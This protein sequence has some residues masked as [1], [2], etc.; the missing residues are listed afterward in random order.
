MITPPKNRFLF[1]HFAVTSI[2]IFGSSV[3]HVVWAQGLP[4]LP[5][6]ALSGPDLET[7]NPEPVNSELP[8]P[9][10]PAGPDSDIFGLESDNDF[11]FEKTPQQ[12]Q[13]EVRTQAFEA[14]LQGLM[15]LKPE[16]IRILLE[17][18]DRTQESVETPIYPPPKPLSVVE[19]LAM[20]PG[21]EPTVIKTAVGN[22]T[23]VNF[24][25]ITGRPWP[26][27]SV[28]WAG[29]FDVMQNPSNG[30]D[31]GVNIIRITP[32]TEYARGNMSIKMIGL[33]T[34][35]IVI[36]KSD[37][38]EVHYRFDATIPQNGPQADIPII[39]KGITLTAG[40]S[41]ISGLLQGI[42]PQSAE[43]LEVSGVD[44]RTSAY[45]YNNMTY[46]RTPLTLLSPGW[47][48]SVSSADGMRV[49]EL[50]AT[51]I[52]LLSENG[53]MVRAQLSDREKLLDE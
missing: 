50:P 4:D 22:I 17:R 10:G 19:T 25:D 42:I 6:P 7:Q 13:D 21:S 34:P 1:L 16:E 24:I 31:Q 29:D 30:E 32:R 3:P 18:F 5:E 44:G 12:L 40:R 8:L 52:V 51:P 45:N 15:P 53:K 27:Q 26:V 38:D 48:N 28:S 11:D 39:N 33:D 9:P 49:Y 2:L 14:A 20:D 23:T 43:K 46:L 37:R 47:N 41:D 36:L 35:I